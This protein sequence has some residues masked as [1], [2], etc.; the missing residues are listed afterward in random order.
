MARM[1]EQGVVTWI[2][3]ERAFGFIR[4]AGV[5][6]GLFFKLDDTRFAVEPGIRVSFTTETDTLSRRKAV[7]VRRAA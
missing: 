1:T 3:R 5:E 7:N 2:N 4:T 6:S